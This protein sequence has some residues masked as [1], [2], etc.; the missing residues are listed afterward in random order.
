ML[1]AEEHKDQAEQDAGDQGDNLHSFSTS[2]RMEPDVS[3]LAK[4]PG[5]LTL[6]PSLFV[7]VD[8]THPDFDSL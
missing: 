7:A 5:A 3:N 6:Q 1:D 2:R 8:C 4:T